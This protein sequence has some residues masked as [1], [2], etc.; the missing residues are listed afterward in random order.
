MTPSLSMAAAALRKADGG[1][2]PEFWCPAERHE[3]G[4]V[5][6]RLCSNKASANPPLTTLNVTLRIPA[7]S[8]R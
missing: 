2:V 1:V 7:A 8:A 5:G 6:K 3:Q 4:S